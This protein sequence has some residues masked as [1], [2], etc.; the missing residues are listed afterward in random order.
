[1]LWNR[2]KRTEEHD[3]RPIE[4]PPKAPEP[5]GNEEFFGPDLGVVVAKAKPRAQGPRGPGRTSGGRGSGTGTGGRAEG[6]PPPP[7]LPAPAPLPPPPNPEPVADP[8][9]EEFFCDDGRAGP[10]TM[11]TRRRDDRGAWTDSIDGVKILFDPCVTP[12]GKHEPHFLLQCNKHGCV[13]RRGC[14]EAHERRHGVIEPLAWLH[15]WHEVEWPT[16]P[17]IMSH[18]GEPPTNDS[19]DRIVEARRAELEDVCRRAGR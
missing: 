9:E 12:A 17:S 2:S 18:V 6:A 11:R 15:A 8:V 10:S 5:I 16:K 4:G 14:T 19:V 13:K 7:P 3:F 1:M